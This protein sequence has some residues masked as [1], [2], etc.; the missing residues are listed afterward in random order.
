MIG[1]LFIFAVMSTRVKKKSKNS[2][3]KKL[4]KSDQKAFRAEKE[5][6]IDLKALA[7]DERTW[8]IF[9]AFLILISLFLFT[10][11]I[12]YLFTWKEDMDVA[13]QGF[14]AFQVIQQ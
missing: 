4:A 12:S 11:F 13:Q 5:E 8:K 9:G 2:P 14:S 10:S 1:K 6:K 7:K 3:E